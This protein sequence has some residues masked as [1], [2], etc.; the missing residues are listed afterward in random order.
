VVRVANG[1]PPSPRPGRHPVRALPPPGGRPHRLR[2]R[3][4]PRPVHRQ[5][6][7]RRPRR[8]GHRPPPRGRRPRGDCRAPAVR[9]ADPGTLPR[10]P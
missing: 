6:R 8:P 3:R 9:L 7:R 1:G 2:P 10:R 4:R 5:G